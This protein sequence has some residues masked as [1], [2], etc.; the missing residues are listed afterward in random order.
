MHPSRSWFVFVALALLPASSGRA[1]LDLPVADVSLANPSAPPLTVQ[2]GSTSRYILP[3]PFVLTGT[4][5]LERSQLWICMDPL[6]TIFYE[7]SGEPAGSAMHY[8]GTDPAGYDR[9]TALAPGLNSARLQNL[10]DLFRAYAPTHTNGLIASAL[11]LAVPE[12]TNEFT[13]NAFSL[14]TGKFRASGG[15]AA[16]NSVIAL[17]QNMLAALSTPGVQNQGDVRSLRF[18]IDG[19]YTNR[20]GGTVPVQD[21]VG[22]VPVPEPATYAVAGGGLLLLFVGRRLV[23]RRSAVVPPNPLP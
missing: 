3:T 22:F 11:Q 18:L 6:Q 23:R 15:S 9:W 17:A 21:L 19:T 1:Q 20:Q 4:L 12:I 5:E 7:H 16:A 10:A 8:A 14:T 2:L 13:G